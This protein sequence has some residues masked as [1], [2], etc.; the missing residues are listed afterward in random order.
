MYVKQNKSPEFSFLSQGP[1]FEEVQ[2]IFSD[3]IQ[4]NIRVHKEYPFVEFDYIVG[5]IPVKY[6]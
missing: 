4:Q 6:V 5:P 2:Q 3:W 1:L